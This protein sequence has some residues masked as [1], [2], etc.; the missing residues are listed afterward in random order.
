MDK[1]ASP[2]HAIELNALVHPASGRSWL[3]RIR[4]FCDAGLLLLPKDG[5]QVQPSVGLDVGAEVGIHFIIPSEGKEQHYR[6]EGNV[7]RVMKSGVGISLLTGMSPDTFAALSQYADQ[8]RM[9]PTTSLKGDE[10]PR[11]GDGASRKPVLNQADVTRVISAL[12]ELALV[13]IPQ[14]AAESFTYMDSELLELAKD[15]KS[16]AEQNEY[17]AAMSV[18]EKAKTGVSQDF[19]GVVIDQIDDP[20]D[21]RTLIEAREKANDLRKAELEEQSKLSLVNT[22]EFEDWLA[23]ANIISRGERMYEQFLGEMLQR[24]GLLVDSWGHL[25]ANPLGV[26]VISH[27]FDS[28]IRQVDMP[29]DIRQKIYGGYEARVLP[30][31]GKLYMNTTALM[32][33]AG[34]FPALDETFVARTPAR[35]KSADKEQV[36]AASDTD[37]EEIND[38][39]APEPA[40]KPRRQGSSRRRSGGGERATSPEEEQTTSQQARDFAQSLSGEKGE[41]PVGNAI[42]SI[43]SSLRDLVS[44]S[45]GN[46]PEVSD[47]GAEYFQQEEIQELLLSLDDEVREFKGD[48]MPVRERLMET[49]ALV[50]GR[51]L[52]PESV[53]DLEVVESLVDVIE[54]DDILAPGAKDWIRKL[55]YTLDKVAARDTDFL[56]EQSSHG[57]MEFINQLARL[58]VEA[59]GTSHAVDQIIQEITDNYD[60][61]PDVF[62]SAV[63]KLSPL[64]ERQSK[65][66]SGNLQRTVKTR[67]GQQTLQ[68]ARE[69]VVSEMDSRYSGKD[70]PEV[71][72]RLLVPGW[73]NL[74]VNT[75]LREGEN[76]PDWKK[77]VRALDQVFLHLEP[78]RDP[79]Q[80]AGYMAPEELIEHIEAGLDSISYEPGQRIPLI[81]SLKAVIAGDTDLQALPRVRLETG[82][83][84]E[85]LD[86]SEVSASV[87]AREK[88]RAKWADDRAW[89]V[90]IERTARL[91]VGAWLELASQNDPQ[92]CI[93]AWIGEGAD[94]FVFVNRRGVKTHDLMVEELATMLLEGRA[95]ILEEADL[96]LSERASHRMLQNMHNQLTHQASHDELTGLLNRKEFERQLGTG[97]E[98]ARR[99]QSQHLCGYLDL[100]QFKVINNTAGH[101]AGD[102]MLVSIA[103]IIDGS[104][105]D[106]E[107]RVARLGGDEFGILLLNCDLDRGQS[108]VK[109]IAEKVKALRF[110]WQGDMF[111]TTVSCGIY[112][113]NED[114]ESVPAI[115]SGADSA[116]IAAK[117]A[118]RDRV[119]VY[120]ENDAGMEHRKDIM[121]FVSRIDTAL[122]EN[123]FELSCQ[124]I[125]PVDRHASD[126]HYEILLTVLDDDYN[127]VPTQDYILAAEQYNRMGALDRWVIAQAFGF[128]SANKESLAGLG[129]FSINVSGNSLS[130]PD[131]L[132][133]VLE[134]FSE[135]QVPASMV[136]FEITETSAIGHLDRVVEFIEKL[137]IIGVSFSLDDFGTGLSSYSYLRTLPVD[138]LKIDG[139]FVKDIKDSPHD[140]AVVKSINEIGHFMGKK[141]IAEYVQD[142]DIVDI[143]RQVGVDYVQGFGVEEKKPITQLLD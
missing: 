41:D 19:L 139:V 138:Y 53:R 25:E 73:R 109:G 103:E 142:D 102:S 115:M 10:S 65:A 14:M 74:L 40:P 8:S 1:R 132:E 120:Q 95:R 122:D 45:T 127:P 48:R 68:N 106:E 63:E 18:L 35:R 130:E 77:H 39:Q 80:S 137:K 59:G 105:K 85:S 46:A 82:T 83:I 113:L 27:S 30:M 31:F 141:T 6:L 11:P 75:H 16:N 126:T 98:S 52:S 100:D 108:L 140:L 47:R 24:M 119:Q 66:F 131:F 43:F 84:A 3:C 69:A 134:Q 114:T 99:K 60:E 128:I 135:S 93:V 44:A 143:L 90:C 49:A 121:E 89:Q 129:A 12:R 88:L 26:A 123:K 61:N 32:E 50:G 23:V 57:A 62:E 9:A 67:Q 94:Q 22:E 111:S 38:S 87:I 51:R 33:E 136:C 58:D 104:L 4:D 71:L 91:H 2:R 28:A 81:N 112:C 54:D 55:E 133:F 124:M 13:A 70:I 15:A 72:L 76:S 107:A 7:V 116:C 56:G 29:Q 21:L 20:R 5:Q 97:L 86:L 42:R 101:E 96:P 118:G 117:E 125:R 92:I 36:T 17:F 37:A 110:N 64:I 79:S 34:I 78:G